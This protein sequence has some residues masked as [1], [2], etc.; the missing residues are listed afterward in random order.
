MVGV[1]GVAK[2]LSCGLIRGP[3]QGPAIL[4]KDTVPVTQ[5]AATENHHLPM[6]LN[7]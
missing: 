5:R 6:E 3:G 4:A 7:L 2:L 1:C